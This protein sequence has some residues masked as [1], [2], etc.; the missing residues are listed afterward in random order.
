M[1]QLTHACIAVVFNSKYIH[2]HTHPFIFLSK[3][4]RY[5]LLGEG[6]FKSYAMRLRSRGNTRDRIN[7]RSKLQMAIS[8]GIK[9][10]EGEKARAN[11]CV[12]IANDAI[13]TQPTN[14]RIPAVA[15]C[16]EFCDRSRVCKRREW[17]PQTSEP[18][19]APPVNP[20]AE[21]FIPVTRD[22]LLRR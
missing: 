9:C 20:T 7:V 21:H 15:C 8:R 19:S 11:C 16:Q 18:G 2:T 5:I 17:Q 1:L 3:L 12:V 10:G 22:A 13:Q 6:S 14:K 4:R